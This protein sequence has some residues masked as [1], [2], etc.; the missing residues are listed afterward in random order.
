MVGGDVAGARFLQMLDLLR[1]RLDERFQARW[2]RDFNL[3]VI[4][5]RAGKRVDAD[6]EIIELDIGAWPNCEAIDLFGE[7]LHLRRQPAH[8]IVGCDVC[9]HFAQRIERALKLLHRRRVPLGDDQIDLLRERRD[10]FVVTDQ[11]FSRHKVAQGIAHLGQSVFDSD[12]CAAVDAGF[13]AFRDALCQNLNLHLERFN[14]VARQRLVQRTADVSELGAQ[15]SYCFF[16]GRAL[17]SLDLLGNVAQ[18]LF[19]S[20]ESERRTRRARGHLFTAQC[21]SVR[22]EFVY[23][24]VEGGRRLRAL[25]CELRAMR[26]DLADAL[27]EPLD[28]VCDLVS[29][30]AVPPRCVSGR[31]RA[32]DMF[33]TSSEVVEAQLHPGEIVA[34]VAIVAVRGGVRL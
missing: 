18:L 31:T 32:R 28:R 24:A 26:C 22:G 33:D 10:G 29:V 5:Q 11:I 6:C 1:Q 15:G 3:G 7:R 13:A 4:R 20:I 25:L 2:H 8:R 27:L 23:G 21:T 19:Q 34:I 30:A 9:R 14:R 16:E 17:E 12:E